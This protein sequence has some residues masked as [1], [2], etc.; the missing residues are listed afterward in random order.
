ME[1]QQYLDAIQNVIDNGFKKEGRN[2]GT[3]SFP[4]A[5]MKY[6]LTDGTLPMFTTKRVFWKGV[7]EELLWF[8]RGSTSAKELSDKGV[9]I[10]DDNST[11]EFLDSR[12]LDY[13]EGELGPVYGFQWRHWGAEY[14]GVDHD[15]TGEGIDQLANV[16]HL[17]KTDP[18]NRRIIM[19]AW[20]VGELDKMALPPC[21]SFVQFLVHGDR[22]T[23]LMYQRSADMG[24]GV[25]FNVTSYS[26][27]T[28]MVAH[29]TGLK[30]HQFVH[31]I[32]DVHVYNDHIGPLKE[33]LTREPRPF[34]KLVIK[35]KVDSI[36]D[37]V[38]KDFGVEGY[39]PYPTIK[40]KMVV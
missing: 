5:M 37:F 11:R 17:L 6:S 26:L 1:E 27:L 10:W 24:L 8:I 25:P 9:R 40:M 39:N 34:P 2:G 19:S 7:R 28:H 13:E 38:S 21:H 30:A 15:Y 16:I 31:M 35:R 22:L 12:C 36:D 18:Y 32:G 3:L 14:K 4:G 29:V 33:Q 23:C 20:N